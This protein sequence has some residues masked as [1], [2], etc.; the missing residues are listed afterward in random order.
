[1]RFA[2]ILPSLVAL[3]ALLSCN[4]FSRAA[5]A[6]GPPL[7]RYGFA[8]TEPVTYNYTVRI[9]ASVAGSKT[10]RQTQL[11]FSAASTPD[12]RF[13]LMHPRVSSRRSSSARRRSS[14]DLYRPSPARRAKYLHAAIHRSA[15]AGR[16]RRTTA[17]RGPRDRDA[18]PHGL[19]SHR[20]VP[21]GGR[22]RPAAA[23]AGLLRPACDRALARQTRVVLGKEDRPATG[24]R[25]GRRHLPGE[26]SRNVRRGRRP[27]NARPI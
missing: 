20:R 13:T 21:C 5:G 27:G 12:G 4:E 14:G 7:L 19:Y 23:A 3:A 24:G 16:G 10:W 9:D 6:E 1:M 18:L 17:R 22:R 11:T 25:R 2:P 15:A 8:K 26:R